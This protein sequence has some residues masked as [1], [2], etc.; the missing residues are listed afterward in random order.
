MQALPQLT[1]LHE[2]CLRGSVLHTAAVPAL[3]HALPQ[4]LLHLDLSLAE[5]VCDCDQHCEAVRGARQY[6]VVVVAETLH[7]VLKAGNLPHLR[8]LDASGSCV[9]AVAA[10]AVAAG[11]ACAPRLQALRLRRGA[12]GRAFGDAGAAALARGLP[13]CVALQRLDVT[14]QRCSPAALAELQQ[15]LPGVDVVYAYGT[16]T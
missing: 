14:G 2:L 9:S 4:N 8:Q 7:K 12:S 15:A 3:L 1:Q 6:H 13:A 10:A 11:A 16:C 5:A